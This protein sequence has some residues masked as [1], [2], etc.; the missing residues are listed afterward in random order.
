[1]GQTLTYPSARYPGARGRGVIEAVRVARF[2]PS[3]DLAAF[4]RWFEIVESDHLVERTLLPEPCAILGYR[5]AG[6]AHLI[7]DGVARLMPDLA[8]TGLRIT[9]RRMRTAPGSGIVLAKLRQV[10]AP[11]LLGEPMHRLFGRIDALPDTLAPAPGALAAAATDHARIA[12]VEAALRARVPAA[13]RADGLIA[14]AVAEIHAARG[15]LRIG[16]LA[17]GLGVS[18]DALE[19]RFRRIVG[20]S[21][22]QYASIVQLR[23]AV[24]DRANQP[25]YGDVALEGGFYDQAHFNR[26][27][28]AVTGGSP[29]QLLDTD[30]VC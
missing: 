30:E 8:L 27:F 11:A 24:D 13:W 12:V 20:A 26:R 21:P 6:A 19:K 3:A 2:A 18:Q 17:A 29:T 7:E 16:A 22:K 23:E 15:T 25:S 28:R 10:G 1:V 4:V 5:Y 9:S 14:D